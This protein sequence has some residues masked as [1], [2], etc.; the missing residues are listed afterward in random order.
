MTLAIT[1]RRLLLFK[2]GN[3][4]SPKPE[5][6]LSSVPIGEVE[7]IIVGNSSGLTRPVTLN[8]HGQSY[9]LEVR[10]AVDTTTLISSFAQVKAGTS[11]MASGGGPQSAEV[12]V[13]S[14]ALPPANWYGDPQHVARL[15]YWDGARWTDH[16]AA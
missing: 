11:T 10:R 13:T 3:G 8:I 14:Q 9:D 1:S 15:R 5:F 4:R 6:L 16:T 2:F 7:S 12:G